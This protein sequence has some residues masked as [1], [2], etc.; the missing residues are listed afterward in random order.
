MNAARAALT[1]AVNRAIAEG[2]PVVVNVP[3]EMPGLPPPARGPMPYAD[4]MRV[5]ADELAAAMR[6][7]NGR[8]VYVRYWPAI[9]M[10]PGLLFVEID[11]EP[12]PPDPYAAWRYKPVPGPIIVRP[13]HHLAW[14]SVPYSA[15]RACL[16]EAFRREPILGPGDDP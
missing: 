4:Q 5:L 9:V 10:R 15:M 7:A 16:Y 6:R 11:G 12:M 13:M 8:R 14:E 3:L 2:A 1:R